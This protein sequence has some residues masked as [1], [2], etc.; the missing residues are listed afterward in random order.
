MIF[1]LTEFMEN[2]GFQVLFLELT[3]TEVVRIWT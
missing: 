2:H 1:F 3:P